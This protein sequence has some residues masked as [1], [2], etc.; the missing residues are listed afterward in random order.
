MN[1]PGGKLD[2]RGMSGFARCILL[3]AVTLFCFVFVLWLARIASLAANDDPTLTV[4]GP[5]H[6]VTASFTG[7]RLNRA[8]NTFDTQA[9]VTHQGATPISA[10]LQLVFTDLPPG[11]TLTNASSTDTNGDPYLEIPL[12]QG[13]LEPRNILPPILI[14]F[15]NPNRLS[16]TFDPVLR[17]RIQSANHP[18]VANAGPDQTIAVGETII[19]DG[20]GSHNAD[21][22]PLTYRWALITVPQ[23]S[24]AELAEP[25]AVQTAFTADLE[26]IYIAQLIYTAHRVME[27]S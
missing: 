15:D 5:E 21:N 13:Q 7:L 27:I 10:P 8:S 18:P 26:G 14:K 2:T 24:Q 11:V 4:L 1:I 25:T 20:S 3:T 19:L 22:D 6:G 9:T 16:I 12:P 23:G 17:G